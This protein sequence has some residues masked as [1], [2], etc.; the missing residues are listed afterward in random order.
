MAKEDKKDKREDEAEEGEAKPKAAPGGRKKLILIIAGVFALVGVSIGGTVLISSLLSKDEPARKVAKKKAAPVEG[1]EEKEEGAA[2]EGEEKVGDEK[3]AEGEE[4]DDTVN[5]DGSKRVA[6]YYDFEQPF[7]VN[8]MDEGQLRYLQIT[9]SVMKF[10][11][12][13]CSKS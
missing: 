7:V 10:T 11:T 12:N 6:A 3:Q 5:P 4:E 13:G 8:F 1:E 9:V 2:K